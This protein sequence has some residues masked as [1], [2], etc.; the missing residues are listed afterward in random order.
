LPVS[1]FVVGFLMMSCEKNYPPNILNTTFTRTPGNF[2]TSF[3]LT[4]EASD[5]NLDEI[6]YLWEASEGTFDHP[7]RNE[8]TWTGPESDV[9][10]EYQISITCSDGKESVTETITIPVGAP[11]YG[12]LSGYAYFAKCKI[13]IFEA[14]ISIDNKSDTTDIDGFFE[15]FGVKGGR[16]TLSGVK[17][18]FLNGSVDIQIFEGLNESDI[19]LS[20]NDFTSTISGQCKGNRSGEP[21]PWMEVIILNPNESE[22]ELKAL[23][24]GTGY[25]EL[26]DVPHGAR[27]LI[28]KDEAGNIKM[29][30]QLF[31]Q[32]EDMVFDVPIKEPFLITDP[33]DNHEYQAVKIK[34]QTWMIENLAYMPHVSP[35][36]E[37][38]GIWVYGYSG[39]DV[40]VARASDNYKKYG[41]LYDWNTT[42]TDHG[43][44]KDICPPGWHVP[45][46]DDWKNLEVGLGMDPIEL[47]SVSWRRTGTVGIKLKF[48]SGWENEGNGSNSSSFSALPAG[49]RSTSGSFLGLYGFAYFWTS[50]EFDNNN[51]W[52]RYLYHNREGVGRFTDL[53]N[54]GL[55]VRCVKDN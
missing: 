55:I 32:E 19:H 12:N 5:P 6:T 10:K 26:N 14:I 8:T 45:S 24:D 13:P 38:G 46:D 31:I 49:T 18:G 9:D 7:D 29:E 47:D 11:R 22:S 35:Q 52:R 2:T 27:K 53:K 44:G 15:L 23:S 21:K 50:D 43:N 42:M 37:Q 33:R 36:W 48:D 1:I 16:Q 34:S 4:V 30:T 3:V 54:S 40:N 25:Y 39:S 51:A 28:V 41:C 20:S 17:E